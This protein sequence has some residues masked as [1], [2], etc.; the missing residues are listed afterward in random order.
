M[1]LQNA[2]TYKKCGACLL[3][4]FTTLYLSTID[5]AFA[6]DGGPVVATGTNPAFSTGGGVSSA[7][8]IQLKTAPANSILM[9]SDVVLTIDPHGNCTNVVSLKTSTGNILGQ[10]RLGSQRESNGGGYSAFAAS[11]SQIQHSFSF[12]LPVPSEESLELT[13]TT[14]CPLSYTIAGYTTLP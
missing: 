6:F 5:T 1:L 10:F 4:L 11:P 7:T 14:S 9:V 13:T 8:T 12:G 3:F 2:T